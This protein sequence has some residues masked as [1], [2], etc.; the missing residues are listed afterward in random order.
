VR[1]L[2]GTAIL[3]RARV[4]NVVANPL[5]SLTLGGSDLADAPELV[6]LTPLPLSLE[7]LSK[8]WSVFFQIPYNLSV[9]YQA[10]VVQIEGAE[11]PL[12]ALPVLDRRVYVVPRD[13]AVIADV[14]SASGGPI[15]AGA[16]LVLKGTSLRRH[17]TR[18]SLQGVEAV[19]DSVTDTEVRVILTAPPF[20]ANRLRAGV[21]GVMVVHPLPMGEPP[22]EHAGFHS[23][24]V[25]VVFRPTVL[26]TAAG[27]GQIQVDVDP[28]VRAGQRAVLLLNDLAGTTA[29]QFTRPL[30][31]LDQ[32]TISFAVTGVAAGQYFVRVQVDGAESPLVLDPLDPA[33]G[34]KVTVP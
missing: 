27:G 16:T 29:H 24:A 6:K 8:L 26:A 32:A 17:V 20:P 2:H 28:P 18:V 30:D 5:N 14:A 15:V 7:E 25:P 11:T 4:Q 19:P 9:A 13:A 31:P 3:G 33:F 23:N 34:P 22:V 21:L 10:T 1:A 12:P